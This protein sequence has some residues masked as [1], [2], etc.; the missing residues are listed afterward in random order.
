MSA[1]N[2]NAK[3]AW[4]VE[5]HPE[6]PHNCVAHTP[7]YRCVTFFPFAVHRCYGH[8]P[9]DE[10][11]GNLMLAQSEKH[12]AGLR[13]TLDF[14]PRVLTP[15]TAAITVVHGNRR[16]EPASYSE[17]VAAPPAVKTDVLTPRPSNNSVAKPQKRVSARRAEKY[18]QYRARLAA[19]SVVVP[20]LVVA[21]VPAERPKSPVPE[22][23]NVSPIEE[24]LSE[25]E[26]IGDATTIEG[27][28]GL[29]DV[30]IEELFE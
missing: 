16:S 20:L 13:N 29:D 11:R 27:L 12:L 4:C 7:N 19:R 6:K 23:E 24:P 26:L 15:K 10:T 3:Y 18:E 25:E 28:L 22:K 9:V 5:A 14:T 17:A 8:G 1:V 30:G 2:T 21:A